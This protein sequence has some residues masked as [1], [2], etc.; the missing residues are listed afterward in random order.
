LKVKGK[1]PKGGCDLGGNRRLEKISHRRIG[2]HGKKLRKSCGKTEIDGEAWL[3][4]NSHKL[5]T[6]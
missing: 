6:P 1:W 4:D 3:S 2:D 5:E